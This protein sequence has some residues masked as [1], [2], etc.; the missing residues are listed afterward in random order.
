MPPMYYGAYLLGAQLL[1]SEGVSERSWAEIVTRADVLWLPLMAGCTA[2]ALGCALLGYV[3]THLF[4][5]VRTLRRLALR[6]ARK[7]A[8]I[9]RRRTA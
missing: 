4:W 7:R 9:A 3:G 6:R 5:R 1:G 2:L 8:I